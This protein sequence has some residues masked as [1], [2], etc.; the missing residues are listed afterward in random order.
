MT[1]ADLA[2]WRRRMGWPQPKAAAALD[3]PLGTYRRWEQGRN[4]PP[5]LLGLLC[6]YVEAYGPLA[7]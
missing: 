3:T 2:A 7:A 5:A 4:D 1:P 6:R